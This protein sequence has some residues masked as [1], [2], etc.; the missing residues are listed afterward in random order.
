VIIFEGTVNAERLLQFGAMIMLNAL[1]AQ[2]YLL[3]E[4]I[5]KTFLNCNLFPAFLAK[6]P[7]K[8]IMPKYLKRDD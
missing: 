5:G 1:K 2:N 6:Y 3:L 7:S 4:N 8:G